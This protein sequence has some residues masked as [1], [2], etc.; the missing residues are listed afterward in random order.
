MKKPP[1]QAAISESGSPIGIETRSPD[2]TALDD[3]QVGNVVSDNA[4]HMPCAAAHKGR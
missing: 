3:R 4:I 1:W 2:P